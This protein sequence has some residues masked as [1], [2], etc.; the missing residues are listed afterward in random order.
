VKA[1]IW[2]QDKL[3]KYRRRLHK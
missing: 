3:V 1:S 2:T